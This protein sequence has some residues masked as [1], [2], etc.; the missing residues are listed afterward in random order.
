MRARALVL[1]ACASLLAAIPAPAQD[2]WEKARDAAR[3]ELAVFRQQAD[4]EILALR[5][6][7][8]AMRRELLATSGRAADAEAGALVL[9][10][11]LE[12]AT[13]AREAAEHEAATAESEAAAAAAALD[14]RAAA[15]GGRADSRPVADRLGELLADY[16]RRLGEAGAI[17]L[18]GRLVRLGELQWIEALDGDRAVLGRPGRVAPVGPVEIPGLASVVDAVAR[19]NPPPFVPID[20]TGRLDLR[21]PSGVGDLAGWFR[22]G[23]PI[24]IVI[25]V[26]GG[27]GVLLGTIRLV[28]MLSEPRPNPADVARAGEAVAAGDREG[29]ARLL[30]GRRGAVHAAL[31]EVALVGTP[32][33]ATSESRIEQILLRT[34]EG[35]ERFL[36]LIAVLAAVSPLLGLLG[37]VIGMIKMFDAMGTGVDASS[38]VEALSGGIGEAL[39]T[40]EAGL[41]F[42][43]PLILLHAVL[44]ARADRLE[45]AL[46]DAALQVA[47]RPGAA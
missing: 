15:A 16:E 1:A 2:A 43:I 45:A 19:G 40:T 23:G 7:V 39:I 35:F 11:K 24:V 13:R 14:E 28:G 38:H 6:S 17:R 4:R 37:T 47:G 5:E 44:S 9:A 8:A 12:D 20:P 27:I 42:A 21:P 26:L 25:F 18:E 33:D 31:A 29:A 30:R 46:E 32:G 3:A 34:V 22:A 41:F 10:T 36:H